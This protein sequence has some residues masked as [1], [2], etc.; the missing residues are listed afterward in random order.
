MTTIEQVV[1][2]G[3]C[4]QCGTCAGTCPREAIEMRWSFAQGWLPE[5]MGERCDDCGACIAVCPGRGLDFS[6]NA[7]W[8]TA[9][10]DAPT[11]DFLGPWRGLWFGWAADE[12][13]RYQGASGGVV[14]AILVAAL[15]DGSIEAAVVVRPSAGNALAMEPLVARAKEEIEVCRGSKYNM[16]ALNCALREV[17]ER[18]GRYALVGLPC[19]IQGLRLAQCRDR[20]LR[21]RVVLAVGIFCGWSA[22]PRATALAA[23]RLGL[24]PAELSEVRYRGPGWPGG[25]RLETR[26]GV[27]RERAYPDY[28]DDDR[29]MRA[30]TPPRCRFCPDGLAELADLSVGDAWLKRFTGSEGVSDLIARTPAGEALVKRLAGDA[31]TLI[32]AGPC[33]MLRSQRETQKLK[34]TVC[35]GRL[36]VRTRR[37]RRVPRYPGLPLTPSSTDKLAGLWDAADEAVHRAVVALRFGL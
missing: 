20:R 11:P 23:R 32:P 30:F 14:T 37:G 22:Q 10:A 15:A 12:E 9:N 17:R 3:L 35:R 24:D 6:M 28:Y 13:I 26:D 7:W 18:P 36:W 4:M 27:V 31:L 8:R 19:H 21:E 5:L 2:D 29:A 33:E 25:L 34:R 1:A 16:V